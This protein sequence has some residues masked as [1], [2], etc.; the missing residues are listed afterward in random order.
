MFICIMVYVY[1]MVYAYLLVYVFFYMYGM[2][3]DIRSCGRRTKLVRV[4]S[5]GHVRARQVDSSSAYSICTQ[6]M[7]IIIFT[8]WIY[9]II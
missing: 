4:R 3:I 2:R 6:L 9:C 1:V 7:H 8:F 5:A